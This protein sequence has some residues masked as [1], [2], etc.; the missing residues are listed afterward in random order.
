[1]ELFHSDIITISHH[2]GLNTLAAKWNRVDNADDYMDGIKAFKREF[3]KLIHVNTLWDNTQF[4]FNVPDHLKIWTD[5]F[6]NASAVKS[7][8]NK[9]MALVVGQEI[10]P[11]L[12]VIDLV[13]GSEV[14]FQNG[15]FANERQA[16]EW[17]S[18][19]D[20]TL[21]AAEPEWKISLLENQK[22]L[23]SLEVDVNDLG[24]YL[25]QINDIINERKFIADRL[26]RFNLL[27]VS[28]KNILLLI[29]KGN[30]NDEIAAQQFIS[31]H[32]V[33]THRKNIIQKLQSRHMAE[34][35]LYRIFL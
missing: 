20:E 8:F 5:Q 19:K 31:V 13:K 33:K 35:M 18:R 1:M 12:S 26:N 2:A 24:S 11:A 30:S 22:A 10:L 21:P 6:L 25:K 32:T 16:I 3:E 14:A 17:I 28:E 7:G 9:K 4:G 15:F 29:L 34:L 27:T 23:I